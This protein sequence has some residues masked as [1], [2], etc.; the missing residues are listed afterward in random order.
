MI[1]SGHLIALWFVYLVYRKEK[2]NNIVW[3]FLA[4]LCVS[5]FQVLWVAILYVYFHTLIKGEPDIKME[6]KKSTAIKGY[7]QEGEGKEDDHG[8]SGQGK[9]EDENGRDG[10]ENWRE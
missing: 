7:F 8:K 9:E 6:E 5:N 4:F 10:K 1:K 3:S 2:K